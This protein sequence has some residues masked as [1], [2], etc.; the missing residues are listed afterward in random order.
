MG[1]VTTRIKVENWLDVVLVATGARK[2]KPR[3]LETDALVDTGAVK[4]YLKSSVISEL[5]LRPVGEVTS[6]TMS[7]RLGMIRRIKKNKWNESPE[8]A[9][10]FLK[11]ATQNGWRLGTKRIWGFAAKMVT[12]ILSGAI[13]IDPTKIGR[14]VWSIFPKGTDYFGPSTTPYMINY[15]VAN[16][17]RLLEQLRCADVAIEKI[18]DYDYGRFAWITDPEGNRIELWEPKS[19]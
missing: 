1:K 13:R 7:N 6:R 5:G 19:A 4:L 16:L 10:S 8:S 15:R 14:T 11:R 2:K 9:E 12:R 17:D 3:A 18:E